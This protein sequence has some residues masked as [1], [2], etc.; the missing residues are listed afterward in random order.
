MKKFLPIFSYVFHPLFIPVMATLFYFYFGTNYFLFREIYI[1][2]IQTVIVTVIIPI[3]FFWLLYVLKK[4][5]SIMVADI[6][7]RKIPLLVQTLLFFYLIAKI[8]RIEYFHELYFCFLAS[9]ASTFL[10]FGLLFLRKKASLHL[11]GI[12]GFLTFVILLSIHTQNNFVPFIAFLVFVC[13]AVASS[14]LFMKAHTP[15][16]LVLGSFIG[17]LPQL[18]FA[19][20]WV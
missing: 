14:R 9:I 4:A 2:I 10:A 11:M 3:L 7:Q 1:I 17:I 13:G 12:T 16:E 8:I 20:F 18:A 5:D 19:Y 15:K 6:N